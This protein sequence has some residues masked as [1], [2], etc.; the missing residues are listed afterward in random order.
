MKLHVF[1]SCPYCARVRTFIGL[2]G[3]ECDINSIAL[4]E[5]PALV[6]EKLDR[7]TVPVLEVMKTENGDVTVLAE[8]LDIIAMLDKRHN[9]LFDSYALSEKLE[10]RIQMLKPISAQLL[11]PRM[12][13]LHLPELA[14]DAAMNTFITS[15]EALLRQSLKQALEKTEE[16]LPDLQDQLLLLEQELNV[17][18]YLSGERMLTIDDIAAFAELRSYTMIAELQFNEAMRAYI[19]TIAKRASVNIYS[20]IS[21]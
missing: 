8:S 1:D 11:Y 6:S 12:P 16:Y 18:A 19:N 20:P 14:N 15:R 9:P 2:K 7:F 3:I 5:K 21:K 13:S 17:D 10:G 4:G